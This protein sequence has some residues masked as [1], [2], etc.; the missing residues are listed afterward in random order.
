MVVVPATVPE[1]AQVVTPP[2]ISIP[3]SVA[4]LIAP[5]VLPTPPAAVT[6]LQPAVPVTPPPVPAPGAVAVAPIAVEVPHNPEHKGHTDSTLPRLRT[7]S[8]DL[9]E[10]IKKKGTTSASIVQAERERAARELQLSDEDIQRPSALKNPLLL[11][12]TLALIAVG[13]VLVGGA[14]LYSILSVTNEPEPIESIIFPNRVTTIDVPEFRSLPDVLYA[15]RSAA[16]LSLGEIL[17][18]DTTILNAT[19]SHTAL[20]QKFDPPAGLLREARSVMLGVHSF[21]RNQPFIIIEVTQYDRAYG[22]MLQWEADMGRGLGAFFK[23]QNGTA[24]P[25]TTFTD[26]VYQNI[27]I[28]ISQDEW[29]IVYAFPQR[30][31]LVITTSQYTL[32]E[33]I[34]RLNAQKSGTMV[35]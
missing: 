17:R 34:T 18:V 3:E 31:V 16:D 32:Q 33:V 15:E 35:P 10:E 2:I 5:I 20:L 27:D 11:G 25:T 28:R 8:D 4:P 26:R 19:T 13:V 30:D 6:P 1:P 12:G 9:S 29:P 21:N 22:A 14:Y 24:P 23:P 7:F